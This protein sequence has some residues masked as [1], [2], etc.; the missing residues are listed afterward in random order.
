MDD[1][2]GCA[3]DCHSERP[4]VEQKQRKISE[5][6]ICYRH[7]EHQLRYYRWVSEHKSIDMVTKEMTVQQLVVFPADTDSET[8]PYP[9]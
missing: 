8:V 2:E 7:F 5:S 4:T 1:V 3:P 9:R 6:N